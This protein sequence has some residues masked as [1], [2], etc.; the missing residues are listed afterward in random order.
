[1]KMI[2]AI[3]Q[4][5]D[6]A[7]VLNGLAQRGLR[8]TKISTTGGFLRSG[9]STILAGVDDT[10]VAGVMDI[11]RVTCRSRKVPAAAKG[12][13]ISAED[14]FMLPA[15]VEVGGANIFVWDIEEYIRV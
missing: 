7:A 2:M 1:M 5:D 10:Q 12:P 8:A 9:N 15:E 3:V 11:L 14:A 13:G 6:V 4:D